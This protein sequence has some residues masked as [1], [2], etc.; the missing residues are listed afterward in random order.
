MN[1]GGAG[2]QNI[3]SSQGHSVA[4]EKLRNTIIG[5]WKELFKIK[6]NNSSDNQRA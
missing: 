1:L 6:S 5:C 4:Y 3:L 2:F